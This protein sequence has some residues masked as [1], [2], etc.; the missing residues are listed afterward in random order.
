MEVFSPPYLFK[1][2]RP[3]I[4]S[5]PDRLRWNQNFTVSCSNP[6]GITRAV[7]IR[8]GSAT[9]GFDADQRLVELQVQSPTATGLVV[10]APPNCNIAPPGYYMLFVVNAVGVPSRA[11]IVSCG[12]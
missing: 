4:V 12:G 3:T 11:V 2:P 5:A 1:G 8:C 9:H 10:K 6:A 7:L